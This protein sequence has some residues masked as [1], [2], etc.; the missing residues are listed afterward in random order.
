[1]LPIV[2]IV[3]LIIASNRYFSS[4]SKATEGLQVSLHTVWEEILTF[5]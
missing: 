5:P 4:L 1:M 2:F 3:T